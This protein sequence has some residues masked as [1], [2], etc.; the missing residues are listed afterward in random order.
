ML[1][2]IQVTS[3]LV[4]VLTIGF[5]FHVTVKYPKLDCLMPLFTVQK[6]I[7][8]Y[9]GTRLKANIIEKNISTCKDEKMPRCKKLFRR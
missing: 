6:L 1:L 9:L 2:L 8:I 7:K 5:G 3:R 4:D